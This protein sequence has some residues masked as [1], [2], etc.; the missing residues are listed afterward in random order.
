[1]K[2]LLFIAILTL[3]CFAAGHAQTSCPDGSVCLPQSTVNKAAEI[4]DKYRA[5]LVTID[6]LQSQVSALQLTST[7]KDALVAKL[8]EIISI[9]AMKDTARTELF[10]VLASIDKLKDDLIIQ[11]DKKLAAN[12]SFFQKLLTKIEILYYILSATLLIVK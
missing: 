6:A 12:K 1:M 10:A 3:A 9:N 5:S 2:Q 7:D 8:R 4:A 11:K